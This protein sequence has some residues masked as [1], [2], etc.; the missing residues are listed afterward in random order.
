M[1]QVILVVDDEPAFCDVVCEILEACGYRAQRAL[2]VKQAY[3][4]MAEEV[5]D[6]ILTDVMMP[7][8]DGLTFIRNLKTNREYAHIPTIV[9]SACTTPG[10]EK[11]A[12]E[13]GAMKVLAKPFSSSDLEGLVNSVI[14]RIE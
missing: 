1:G 14:R 5:P 6:L 7:E 3:Q 9:V 12:L 4:H 11:K 10:D 13:A 8:T 2:N